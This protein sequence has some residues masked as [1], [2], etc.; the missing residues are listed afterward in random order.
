MAGALGGLAASPAGRAAIKG[1]LLLGEILP[2]PLHPLSRLTRAPSL[3]RLSLAH[4]PADLYERRGGA[5]GMV[6]VHGA[7]IGG[8]DDPRIQGLAGAFA[9]VGRSVLVPSLNLA[10]RRLDLVDLERILDAIA[11]QADRTGSVVVVAFS[12]GGALTLSA[13]AERPAIQGRIRAV[14]TLGTYFD[15]VHLIQGVTTG[16][17]LVRGTLHP[18][19]PPEAAAEQALPLLASF[20]GGDDAAAIGAGLAAGSGDG[21]PAGARAVYDIITNTDPLRTAALAEA[22]PAPIREVLDR[23]SP[24]R[25]AGA[26]RV[27]VY[28]LHSRVDP[29]SPAVESAELVAAVRAADRSRLTLVGG[30]RHVTPAGGVLRQLSDLPALIRYAARL[31]AVQEPWLPRAAGAPGG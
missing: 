2:S 21:L 28:A 16:Q 4:G 3:R 29:A 18:W 19:R 23:L 15:I 22:L 25:H 20:L 30:M 31:L 24:A 7:N 14:A 17:V 26:I 11:W 8:I 1:T 6:L 27:P 13:V 10:E 12:Y 9:R 5:P